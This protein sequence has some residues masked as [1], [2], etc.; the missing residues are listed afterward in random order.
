MAKQVP[1]FGVI[2]VVVGAIWLAKDMGWIRFD[3]PVAPLIV[4]A[5]GAWI[6]YKKKI[7]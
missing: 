2:L 4:L 3:L 7:Q 1:T 6:I 5:L